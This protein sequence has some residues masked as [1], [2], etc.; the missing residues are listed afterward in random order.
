MRFR[1]SSNKIHSGAALLHSVI[2]TPANN[3]FVDHQHS[4]DGDAAFGQSFLASSIA[5]SMNSSVD[6]S[7]MESDGRTDVEWCDLLPGTF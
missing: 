2:M 3:P 6:I 5:D 4:A 1:Y 7:P